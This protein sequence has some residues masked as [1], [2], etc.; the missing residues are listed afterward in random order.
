LLHK[1]LTDEV[2]QLSVPRRLVEMGLQSP[3]G[4]ELHQVVT[5]WLMVPVL[6]VVVFVRLGS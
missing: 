1:G 5:S 4:E 6:V 2:L 3:V